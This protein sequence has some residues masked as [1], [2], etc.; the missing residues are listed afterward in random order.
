MMKNEKKYTNY[1]VNEKLVPTCDT[2]EVKN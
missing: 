1:K 2:M